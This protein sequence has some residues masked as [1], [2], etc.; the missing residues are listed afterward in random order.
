[1]QETLNLSAQDTD[2]SRLQLRKRWKSRDNSH[3]LKKSTMSNLER[4]DPDVGNVNMQAADFRLQTSASLVKL[5][6]PCAFC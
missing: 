5:E 2:V 4:L 1:M 6:G 3:L